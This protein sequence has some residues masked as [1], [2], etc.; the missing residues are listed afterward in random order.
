MLARASVNKA[1]LRAAPRCTADAAPAPALASPVSA[2]PLAA[3]LA[4]SLRCVGDCVRV[5]AAPALHAGRMGIVYRSGAAAALDGVTNSGATGLCGAALA[6][7]TCQ[8]WPKGRGRRAPL[9]R[10]VRGEEDRYGAFH[11]HH[12]RHAVPGERDAAPAL[13]DLR[14]RAAVCES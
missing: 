1:V 9:R 13:P 12:L 14:G 4:V 11:L 7:W 5:I 6:G 3:M 10:R 2:A 8:A